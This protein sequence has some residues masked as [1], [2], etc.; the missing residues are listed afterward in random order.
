MK[1]TDIER[2][3]SEIGNG[4]CRSKLG[5]VYQ[6]DD[7]TF[8]FTLAGGPLPGNLLISLKRNARR[9]HLVLEKIH[10]DFF[11]NAPAAAILQ[12]HCAGGRI[13]SVNLYGELL[14]L[15]INRDREFDMFVHF[16]S[17]NLLLQDAHGMVFFE[18]RG[19][20]GKP[21]SF[22]GMETTCSYPVTGNGS[23]GSLEEGEGLLFNRKL[24]DEYMQQQ[25]AAVA[26]RVLSIVR[27]ERRKVGRLID[28]LLGER[29]EVQDKE[30]YRRWGELLKYNLSS[31]HRGQRSV[32]LSGFNGGSV[33]VELDPLLGPQEN[34]NRYFQRYRKLKRREE[35]ID[36]K[37]DFEQRRLGALDALMDHVQKGDAI[38]MKDPPSLFVESIDTGLLTKALQERMRRLFYPKQPVAKGERRGPFLRFTSRKGKTIFVGRSAS[39]NEE[40]TLRVARGNDLWFHVET[41]SGSHV[42]LRYARGGAFQDAD[43]VDAAMLALYFSPHRSAG[44][45]DIVY[46]YRKYVRKPKNKPAGYVTYYN[47]R[48]KHIRFDDRVLG[49]LLDTRPQGLEL[50]R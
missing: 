26:R 15:R 28:K 29:Q 13:E 12:K 46:T 49:S 10:R 47:N 22:T 44:S 34:M 14:K 20:E 50:K 25:K 2:A 5:S 3:L 24:S 27:G 21:V 43:I 16:E 8:L 31:I 33:T 32:T 38:S 40:L 37:I 35:V 48:T 30:R 11:V 45:G 6:R 39:E 42:I 18:L 36:R 19:G 41:G 4:L 1:R 17:N 9:F 7:H 23:A